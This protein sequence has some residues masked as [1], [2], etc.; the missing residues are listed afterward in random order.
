MLA[1]DTLFGELR[2]EGVDVGT[3]QIEVVAAE[4]GGTGA[5]DEPDAGQEQYYCGAVKSGGAHDPTS[6]RREYRPMRI[7]KPA[8][9]VTTE[10]P[11]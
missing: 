9:S 1:R 4:V 6:L 2:G 10:V 11:P 7:P 8:S 3:R 5:A